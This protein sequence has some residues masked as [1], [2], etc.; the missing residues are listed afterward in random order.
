[1]LSC[2]TTL[3]VVTPHVALCKK[4]A[5]LG[6]A[7]PPVLPRV[8]QTRPPTSQL[9]GGSPTASRQGASCRS[10]GFGV[11]SPPSVR[12]PGDAVPVRVSA[13]QTMW[14]IGTCLLW[15]KM[16]LAQPVSI[17]SFFPDFISHGSV[18]SP[19]FY[20]QPLLYLGKSFQQNVI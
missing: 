9:A 18:P 3:P 6:R 5:S 4:R 17:S 8:A 11:K 16:L 1:M 10:H 14:L 13:C 7:H 2:S 20:F 15:Q 19:I 12:S